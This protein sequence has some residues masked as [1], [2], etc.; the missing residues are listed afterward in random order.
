L[1]EAIKLLEEAVDIDKTFGRPQEMLANSWSILVDDAILRGEDPRPAFDKSIAAAKMS[2]RTRANAD[3]YNNM[4]LTLTNFGDYLARRG[5]D[6]TSLYNEALAAA[7][8]ADALH[9]TE[10]PDMSLRRKGA[11]YLSLAAW[12]MRGGRDPRALLARGDDA[13][14]RGLKLDGTIASS[15]GY[16]A[17][18]NWLR[19]VWLLG[20]GGDASALPAK[21]LEQAKAAEARDT[22]DWWA[23]TLLARGHLVAAELALRAGRDPGPSLA[24]IAAPVAAA[25]KLAGNQR[26]P[27]QV[28]AQAEL[29]AAHYARAKKRDVAAPLDRAMRA[30]EAALALDKRDGLTYALIAEVHRRRAEW[31]GRR[32]EIKPGLAAVEQGLQVSKD[33]PEARLVRAA[34]DGDLARGR[35]EVPGLAQSLLAR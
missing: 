23:Q 34:L 9:P 15:W 11:A 12:E 14:E 2:I 31:L 28:A 24:A 25:S 6:P 22:S 19:A 27:Q 32:E 16:R 20:T 4:A 13:F 17:F 35:Q 26:E 3:R 7:D 1:Q 21:I 30:A 10:T 5:E 33:L 18:G 8:S 29:I